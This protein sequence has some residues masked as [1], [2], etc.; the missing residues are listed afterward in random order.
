M[1]AIWTFEELVAKTQ[2]LKIGLNFL[3]IMSQ[4]TKRNRYVFFNIRAYLFS[5]FCFDMRHLVLWENLDTL[6]FATNILFW[7]MLRDSTKNIFNI[8]SSILDSWNTIRQIKICIEN[9]ERLKF[10]LPNPVFQGFLNLPTRQNCWHESCKIH[11]QILEKNRYFGYDFKKNPNWG[12]I[13][14]KIKKINKSL[15]IA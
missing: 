15:I 12:Y 10:F 13:F 5:V 1:K 4:I 9:N 6:F 7:K 8:L 3:F 11:Y 14:Q 2:N